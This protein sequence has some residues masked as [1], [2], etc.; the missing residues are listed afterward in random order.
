VHRDLKPGSIFLARVGKKTTPKLLDFGISQLAD[1][2][3]A[4]R[5]TTTGVALGTPA[6]MAPEQVMAQ[7]DLDARVDVWA[8]GVILYEM[9]AGKLPFQ[10]GDTPGALYVQIC[11]A[12]PAPLGELGTDV[13]ESYERIVARCMRRER[14]ERYASARELREDLAAFRAGR[15]LRPTTRPLPPATFPS[16]RM[17]LPA[18]RED[19]E[20]I[21]LAARPSTKQPTGSIA[22]PVASGVASVRLASARSHHDDEPAARAF[23]VVLTF[24]GAGA[25]A[26]AWGSAVPRVVVAGAAFILAGMGGWRAVRGERVSVGMLLLAASCAALALAACVDLWLVSDFPRLA[27]TVVP[28]IAVVGPAFAALAAGRELAVAAR[29]SRAGV[30]VLAAIVVVASLA[31]TA[32]GLVARSRVG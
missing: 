23:D 6:Y 14:G 5:I 7:K 3:D 21:A 11:T 25:T 16:Q 9:V 27:G 13:P 19:E 8:L 26:W 12:D 2:S 22:T 17:E 32:L 31:A 30:V 15:S 1:T 28:W 20:T 18:V 4:S 24:L 10:K 29:A